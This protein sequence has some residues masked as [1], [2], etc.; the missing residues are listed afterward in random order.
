MW[1]IFYAEC[2][3]QLRHR[4]EG[5]VHHDPHDRNC[6]NIRNV[7][8]QHRQPDRQLRKAVFIN[9]HTEDQRQKNRDRDDCNRV[10][11]RVRQS[12][13]KPFVAPHIDKIL[14]TDKIPASEAFGVIP[15]RK[16]DEQGKQNRD[17]G[18]QRT[19]DEVWQQKRIARQIRARLRA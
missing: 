13:D 10:D 11:Q 8:H 14:K 3:N 12:V 6:N 19:A 17:K 4:A 18:K 5:G 1:W 15:I 9:E 16:A 2:F 7:W